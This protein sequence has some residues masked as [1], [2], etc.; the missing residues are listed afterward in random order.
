MSQD[1]ECQ[2]FPIFPLVQP[3]RAPSNFHGDAGDDP[4]RISPGCGTR[5]MKKTLIPG[6]EIPRTAK[7]CVWL[8][9]TIHK[10]S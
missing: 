2:T 1:S 8:D 3:L 6:K 4:S 9:G 10:T 7:D 5:I